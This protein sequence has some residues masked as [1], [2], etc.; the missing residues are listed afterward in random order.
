[1]ETYRG[2]AYPWEADHMG[3]MN[4]QF[5]M[6][7]F[8]SATGHLF[9]AIGMTP[10][11]LKVTARGMAAAEQKITY[12]AE[13]F[14]GDLIVV[15]TAITE[16][17]KRSL[18]FRHSMINSATGEEVATTDLVAVHIDLDSRASTKMPEPI[19]QRAEEVSASDGGTS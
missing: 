19:R 3:H 17:S 9:G 6:A 12:L 4:V 13:L 5:Y 1:M 8:D 2:V 11:W 10:T 7:K 15:R 18:H 16:V 14:P